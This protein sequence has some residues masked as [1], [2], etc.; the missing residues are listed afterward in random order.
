MRFD[1]V[2]ACSHL[3]RG[4]RMS[5]DHPFYP[6]PTPPAKV[7]PVNRVLR[8]GNAT[9]L[10]TPDGV[11]VWQVRLDSYD[12]QVLGHYYGGTFTGRD[13]EVY[14]AGFHPSYL[15]PRLQR[16]DAPPD[17]MSP[18]GRWEVV[19]RGIAAQLSRIGQ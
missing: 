5:G 18:V 16:V 14:P 15:Q 10:R 11:Y 1:V 9:G 4:V 8:M 7:L 17:E 12:G 19:R 2:C 3:P 13:G 6:P